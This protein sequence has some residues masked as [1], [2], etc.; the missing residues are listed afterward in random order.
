MADKRITDVDFIESLNSDES[1]FVNQNSTLKQINKGNIIFEIANGGTGATNAEDARENLGAASLVHG[2]NAS[3]IDSGVLSLDRLPIVPISNVSGVLPV[4]QLPI[5][6]IS[7]GGTGSSD[8]AT[9]LNNLF[10]AGYTILSSN[11]YGT[12]LPAAGNKGRIF[13]KKVSG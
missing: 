11:Q 2:H 5:V 12:S 3:E 1:F 13:F 4:D 6:P 8:G 9:G 7:K 10:A